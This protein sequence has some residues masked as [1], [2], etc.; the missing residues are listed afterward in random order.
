MEKG[1]SG[2]WRC[3]SEACKAW[4]SLVV[5]V[6]T[7]EGRPPR[8][9][10]PSHPRPRPRPPRAA[11]GGVVVFS[12]FIVCGYFCVCVVCGGAEGGGGKSGA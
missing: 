8:A 2:T 4:L 9:A 5:P 6:G 11:G 3:W 1:G 7:Q 12:F 10:A